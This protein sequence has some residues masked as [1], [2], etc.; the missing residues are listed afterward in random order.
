MARTILMVGLGAVGAANHV[1]SA[2]A[3]ILDQWKPVEKTLSDYVSEGF[4][5][6]TILLEHGQARPAKRRQ[7]LFTI[8]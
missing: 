6:Q 2:R 8:R 5:I 4:V 1:S 7:R 3:Q